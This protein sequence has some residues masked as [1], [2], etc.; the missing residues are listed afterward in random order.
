MQDSDDDG[1]DAYGGPPSVGASSNSSRPTSALGGPI[2]SALNHNALPPKSPARLR[3]NMNANNQGIDNI[4]DIDDPLPG[5]IVDQTTLLPNDEEGFA[6]APVDTTTV[7][8]LTRFITYY[9]HF[10]TVE[11]IFTN[12]ILQLQDGQD[13]NAKGSS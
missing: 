9:A 8:G 3:E 7:K 13:T 5:G 12:E 10:S 6:L 2:S 1:L 4:P 11:L